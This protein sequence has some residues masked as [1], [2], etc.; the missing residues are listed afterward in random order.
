MDDL[1]LLRILF[2]HGFYA[3]L[4]CM[5]LVAELLVGVS[6]DFSM[7]LLASTYFQRS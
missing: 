1:G 6:A 5:D 2:L 4:P 3:A 7:V